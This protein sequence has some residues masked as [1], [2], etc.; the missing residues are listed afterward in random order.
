MARTF[1]AERTACAKS[2]VPEKKKSVVFGKKIQCAWSTK[3][4]VKNIQGQR[5]ASFVHC[6]LERAR[7]NL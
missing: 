1:E 2:W 3:Y 7:R 4:T 6:G 5:V